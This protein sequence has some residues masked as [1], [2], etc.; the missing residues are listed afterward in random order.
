LQ[1]GLDSLGAVELRNAAAAAFGL[2]L[3]PT[4]AFDHPTPAAL[5]AHV[6][7]ALAAAQTAGHDDWDSQP[8]PVRY[9]RRTAKRRQGRARSASHGMAAPGEAAVAAAVAAA[10]AEVLGAAL[11]PDEPLMEVGGG[12]AVLPALPMWG[13]DRPCLACLDGMLNRP[14]S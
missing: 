13:N 14:L 2:D 3:P 8:R 12:A 6:A 9:G 4:L 10:A 5:A 7:A 1:A 11:G